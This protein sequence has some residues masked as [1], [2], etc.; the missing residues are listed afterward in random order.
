M[1]A[2]AERVWLSKGG[3]DNIKITMLE[4]LELSRGWVLANRISSRCFNK[5]A[6]EQDNQYMNVVSDPTEEVLKKLRKSGREPDW[7]G[8]SNA[9]R[10]VASSLKLAYDT[11]DWKNLEEQRIQLAQKGWV[12]FKKRYTP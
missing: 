1:F 7:A 8:L 6:G 10:S 12:V 5:Q 9:L 4:D 11:A 3:T 2:L